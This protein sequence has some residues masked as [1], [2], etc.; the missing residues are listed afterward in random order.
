MLAETMINNRLVTIKDEVEG[1]LVEDDFEIVTTS[2]T[3]PSIEQSSNVVL[4][5]CLLIS[6]DP[7]Q[8]NRM[9]KCNPSQNSVVQAVK[10]VLGKV[11]CVFKL[12]NLLK[13][14]L[15][16]VIILSYIVFHPFLNRYI[17]LILH[18]IYLLT[19][20]KFFTTNM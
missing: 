17:I 9:K 13:K 5:K 19:L 11:I 2:I 15:I 8:L 18:T 4:V 12:F 16:M 3:M 1:A 6:I 20:T 10:L 14:G 7:F